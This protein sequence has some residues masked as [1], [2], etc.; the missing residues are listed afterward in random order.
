MRASPV[1]LCNS[2]QGLSHI[3]HKAYTLLLGLHRPRFGH[4]C[5]RAAPLWSQHYACIV[6]ASFHVVRPR[7]G[8][9][10][11]KAQEYIMA[12]REGGDEWENAIVEK[13]NDDGTFNVIKEL[14]VTLAKKQGRSGSTVTSDSARAQ[15]SNY[16]RVRCGPRVCVSAETVWARSQLTTAA[17]SAARNMKRFRS[18][19]PCSPRTKSRGTEQR[20]NDASA[21]C[22][23]G[24][25]RMK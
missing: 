2:H 19:R 21:S 11:F 15:V 16:M 20:R 4:A 14:A 13:V 17:S 6:R 3:Y 10:P 1:P 8:K 24:V 18:T 9:Y 5:R 23:N 22:C 7:F 12:K 25:T